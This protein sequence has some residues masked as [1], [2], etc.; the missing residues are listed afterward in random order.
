MREEEEREKRR[1]REEKKEGGGRGKVE[2]KYSLLYVNNR[3]E[4]PKKKILFISVME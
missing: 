1:G 2:G 4:T 3:R